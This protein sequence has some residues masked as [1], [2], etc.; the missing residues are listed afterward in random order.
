MGT[1]LSCMSPGAHL[2]PTIKVLHS[3]DG[4]ISELR[5][6]VRVA[7]LMFEHP[8]QFVCHSNAL[9]NRHRISP[10]SADDE[11]RMGQFYMLLPMRKLHGHFSEEEVAFL[12]SCLGKSK[13]GIKL[14]KLGHSRVTPLPRLISGP[15]VVQ[16][17]AHQRFGCV[18]KEEP[19]LALRSLSLPSSDNHDLVRLAMTNAQQGMICR[20]KSW[21]PNL[22]TISELSM[23]TAC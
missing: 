4:R 23:S 18:R 3:D 12:A 1:H 8:N 15:V 17:K 11:L 16:C 22:E 14:C 21:I 6:P 5:E 7:E 13:S 2:L 10:L 19:R 20:S 9:H